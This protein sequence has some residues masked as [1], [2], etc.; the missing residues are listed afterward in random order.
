MLRKYRPGELCGDPDYSTPHLFAFQRVAG[1]AVERRCAYCGIRDPRDTRVSRP[2]IAPIMP[3]IG[4]AAVLMVCAVL[5]RI[6]ALLE[7][8]A[9]ALESPRSSLLS[10]KERG[11]L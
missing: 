8:I 3:A 9:I 10:P 2:Q 4:G 1:G 6:A 5:P 7:R 11:P